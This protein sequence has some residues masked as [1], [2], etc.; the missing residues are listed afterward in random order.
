MAWV[1]NLLRYWR[2]SSHP[3]PLVLRRLGVGLNR[4]LSDTANVPACHMGAVL[5]V[6]IC[7]F[8]PDASIYANTL[9]SYAGVRRSC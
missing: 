7:R 3:P 1:T 8:R 5:I 9:Q 6:P 4:G 2:E